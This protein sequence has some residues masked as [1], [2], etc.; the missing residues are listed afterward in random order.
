MKMITT[1]VSVGVSM[2]FGC[3]AGEFVNLAFDEPDLTHAQPVPWDPVFLSAPWSEIFQ[4]WT[5]QYDMSVP[6][7]YFD[8][9]IATVGPGG[10]AVALAYLS[11]STEPYYVSVNDIAVSRDLGGALRPPA[12]L[13]QVGLIPEDAWELQFYLSGNE[14]S[15]RFPVFIDGQ[16][17][18][19]YRIQGNWRAIDVSRYAGREVKLEFFFPQGDSQCFVLDIVGFSPIPEPSCVAL[20]GVGGAMVWWTG[21]RRR[22]GP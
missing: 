8:P 7:R 9:D 16:Q 4:G 2:A 19:Y 10:F 22:R 18:D 15:Q 11:P 21:R 6:I 5:L 13:F 20:L 3:I 14:W 17:Q 12:H 1:A